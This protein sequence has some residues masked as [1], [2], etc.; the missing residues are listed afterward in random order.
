MGAV[1][2]KPVLKDGQVCMGT[3]YL[4]VTFDHL[5]V[6]GAPAPEFLQSVKEYLEDR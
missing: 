4:S 5:I 3:M 1:V 6:N 2:E